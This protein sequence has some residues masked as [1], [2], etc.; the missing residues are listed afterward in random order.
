M[1]FWQGMCSDTYRRTG[2]RDALAVGRSLLRDRAMRPLA[3]MRLYQAGKGRWWGRPLYP[4]LWLMH[5]RQTRRAGMDLPLRTAIG[6][7][8]L[9]A[10]STG[11]VVNEQ[12]RIGANVTLFHGVTLG[13]ADRLRSDGSREVT[14]APIIED[15]AWLGP[16]AVVVGPVRIGAGSRILAG[17]VVTC[18]VPPASMVSGNPAQVV[19]LSCQPDTPNPLPP[20]LLG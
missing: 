8:L 13:Q 19:R 7:G 2:R 11:L 18:D 6:P 20:D 14:G 1:D 4:L 12:A 9:I 15:G 17:A 16:H 3:T 10:H 5:R